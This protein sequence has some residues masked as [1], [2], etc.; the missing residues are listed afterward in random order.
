MRY[1]GL[2]IHSISR[3]IQDFVKDNYV[4]VKGDIIKQLWGI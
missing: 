3:T 1:I 4:N 2:G